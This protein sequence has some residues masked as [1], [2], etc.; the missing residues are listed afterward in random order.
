MSGGGSGSSTQTVN[1]KS[2][3]WSG[4]Q[5]SL[6]ALIPQVSQLDVRDQYPGSTVTP[7]SAQTNQY[8]SDLTDRG[9]YGSDEYNAA[10]GNLVGT[11]SGDYLGPNPYA[12]AAFS[13]AADQV[14]NATD[15]AFSRSGRFGSGTHQAVMEEGLNT[16]ADNFYLQN[17]LTERQNQNNA[18]TLAPAIGSMGLTD[19]QQLYVAGGLNEAKANEYLQ[20]VIGKWDY[21]QNQQWQDLSDRIALINGLGGSY[22]QTSSSSTGTTPQP[23]K[24]LGALGG[25]ASGAAIGSAAGPYGAVIGAI[26]GALVGAFA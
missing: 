12:D 21:S 11:L 3:P 10:K 13:H 22:T 8:I 9:V 25:A 1:Q 4:I 18:L 19:T 17:Y 6:T 23:S 24:A 2:D 16:L 14:R 5:P 15:A 20:D 7:Y 26:G